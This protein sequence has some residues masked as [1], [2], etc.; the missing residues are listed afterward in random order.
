MK[1]RGMKFRIEYGDIYFRSSPYFDG[2]SFLKLKPVVS[3]ICV[4]NDYFQR[5]RR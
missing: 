3:Y 2:L 5:V 1:Y 4:F